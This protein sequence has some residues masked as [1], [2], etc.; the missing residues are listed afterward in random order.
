MESLFS[1]VAGL[2]T[3]NFIQMKLQHRYF[4][5]NITEFL[6]I[7]IFIEHLWW[8]LECRVITLKQVKVA[9]SAFLRC[10]FR[11]IFLDSW[12]IGRRI[13]TAESDL[14]KVAPATLPLSLFVVDN[15]L[16]ILQEVKGYLRYKTIISQ[17]A[18]S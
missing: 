7:A 4:P 17:N 5:V 14:S 10:S 9:S 15:F 6:R 3:C 2:K 11:K 12:S 1:K 18:P 16:E 13:S 8:L